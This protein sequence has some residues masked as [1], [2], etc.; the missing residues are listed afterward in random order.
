MN[1]D[2]EVCGKIISYFIVH[3][4]VITILCIVL[5]VLVYYLSTTEVYI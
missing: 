4:A 2:I 1:H 3:S 5:S